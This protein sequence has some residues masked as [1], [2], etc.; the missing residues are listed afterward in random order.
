MDEFERK[1]NLGIKEKFQYFKKFLKNVTVLTDTQKVHKKIL[2]HILLFQ[3]VLSIF[4]YSTPP[5]PISG[6]VR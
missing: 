1:T 6:R 4:L 3:T 2:L 5:L